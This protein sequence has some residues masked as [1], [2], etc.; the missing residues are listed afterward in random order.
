VTLLLSVNVFPDAAIWLQERA[1]TGIVGVA[2]VED[3]VF[4]DMVDEWLEVLDELEVLEWLEV[5]E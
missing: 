1:P 2:E 5:L 4:D 3:V